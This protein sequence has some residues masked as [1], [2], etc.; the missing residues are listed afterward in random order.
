[1]HERLARDPDL[2]VYHYAAYEITALKRLMGRY[3]T[4]EAE[5]DDLLRRGVFVDLYKVVRNGLRASRPGYGLKEMEAF[6]DFHRQA[7]VKDGGSSIVMF[8]EWMQTREQALLDKI[9]A[10]NEEDCIAT[11]LL[12]DWLLERR[13][14]ALREFGPFPQPEPVE[15]K[16]AAGGQGRARR[17]PRGA[18]RRGRGA[19]GAPARLP[20]ARAQAGLVGL[21]R[22]AREDATTSC[23]RTRSRSAAS[24]SP[25][26]RSR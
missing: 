20:R 16:P 8:E 17:A 23:S 1:M 7:E 21:L 19:R 5:L 6:L 14:E 26:G 24:R 3:G 4:R 10:Y 15:P 18:P 25:A 13:A 11:L 2:H 12:R 9:A 22:P